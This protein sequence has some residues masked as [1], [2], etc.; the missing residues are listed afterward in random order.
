MQHKDFSLRIALYVDRS[1]NRSKNI[2]PEVIPYRDLKNLLLYMCYIFS[3]VNIVD[4]ILRDVIF[5]LLYKSL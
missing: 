1:M 3:I 2:L 4:M 5:Y